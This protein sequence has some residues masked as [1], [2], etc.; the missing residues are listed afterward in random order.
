MG[1]STGGGGP[2]V[3]EAALAAAQL[4]DRKRA[5]R[6]CM[7]ALLVTKP[8]TRKGLEQAV[9][10]VSRSVPAFRPT[11]E[12]WR[13][14]AGRVGEYRAPGVYHLRPHLAQELDALS[15]YR[16]GGPL[17]G[18]MC[19]C[20]PFGQCLMRSFDGYVFVMHTFRTDRR[21]SL[22]DMCPKCFT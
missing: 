19:M 8:V 20:S 4:P 17:A 3:S 22:V 21:M 1:A 5:L 15:D 6:L 9:A 10:E 7:I 13:G 14:E 2:M 18:I 16:S 11:P 12:Q